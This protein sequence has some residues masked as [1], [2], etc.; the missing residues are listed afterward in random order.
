MAHKIGDVL[1]S[2]IPGLNLTCIVVKTN[3]DV[4]YTSFFDVLILHSTS[5]QWKEACIYPFSTSGLEWFFE[6]LETKC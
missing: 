5:Y 1:K 2:T 4:G 3:Y 6:K